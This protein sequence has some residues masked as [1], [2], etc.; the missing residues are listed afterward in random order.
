MLA[1]LTLWLPPPGFRGTCPLLFYYFLL[2]FT[3]LFI[4][5]CSALL[6]FA[7][8]APEKK[9]KKIGFKGN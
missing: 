2:S 3:I 5:F 8:M 1:Y 6:C 4:Y 9:G 7:L